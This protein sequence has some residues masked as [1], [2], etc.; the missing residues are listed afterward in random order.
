MGI[1][2][3]VSVFDTKL[4]LNTSRIYSGQRLEV[5]TNTEDMEECCLLARPP[6]LLSQLTVTFVITSRTTCPIDWEALLL[7]PKSVLVH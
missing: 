4:A 2:F 1:I 3:L 5:V 6:G 7:D